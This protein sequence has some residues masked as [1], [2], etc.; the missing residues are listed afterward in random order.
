MKASNWLQDTIARR[1]ATTIVS[2]VLAAAAMSGLF[3]YFAGQ[4]TQPPLSE[5]GLPERGDVIVRML[6]AA[7]VANRPALASVASIPAIQV[8]WYAAGTNVATMMDSR[9]IDPARNISNFQSNGKQ[10]RLFYFEADGGKAPPYLAY[11]PSY[12]DTRF[13]AAA[14]DDGGWVLFTIPTR[15][16]GLNRG[17]RIGIGLSFLV[18]SVIAVSA[19]ATQKLARPIKHFTEAVNRFGSNPRSTPA[20]ETGPRELRRAIAAFNAMQSQI[21]AF[22]DD[23]TSMLAAISHDLRTPLTRMRLRAELIPDEEQK[24]RLFQDVDAMRMMIESALSFFRDDYRDEATTSFD[25]PE[26]LRTIAD[27]YCDQGVDIPY[28]GPVRAAYRG[29][30]FALKRAF[31]NLIDNANLYAKAPEIAL[32]QGNGFVHVTVSDRGPGIPD[33]A[34]ERVFAPFFRLEGSRNRTTGGVGLGL[35]SARAVIRNHGGDISLHARVGGGLDV[36]VSLPSG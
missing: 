9:P 14:L 30:P 33:D 3:V 19:I 6:E 25:F 31:T 22:V 5:G 2:A 26:L 7:P 21:Q 29:R 4:L 20:P 11:D 35:T 18:A 10:R 34:A 12:P 8:E 16:W 13:F 28:T 32:S 23:R 17:M 1:F 27:D 24:R 15:L 36:R